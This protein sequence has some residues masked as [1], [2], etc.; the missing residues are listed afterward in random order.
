MLVRPH[1]RLPARRHDPAQELLHGLPG[2][3][4]GGTPEAR[5]EAPP[6]GLLAGRHRAASPQ[7]GVVEAVDVVGLAD[8]Q[9]QIEGP[10]VAGLEAAEA[11]EDQGLPGKA[12]APGLVEEQAVAAQ[13]LELVLDGG[14][15]DLELLS[16]LAQALAA[17]G[18]QEERLQEIALPQP[19]VGAKRL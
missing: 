9:V 19:V 10:V 16:H 7:G 17:T 1:H 8:Q 6:P 2:R 18:A 13:A 12:R 11:I 14:V 5:L 4:R 15:G 3:L